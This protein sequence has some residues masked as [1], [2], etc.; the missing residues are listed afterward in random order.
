[1]VLFLT[2]LPFISQGAEKDHSDTGKRR[3]P[4]DYHE[5]AGD[6]QTGEGIQKYAED[7]QSGAQKNFGVQPVHD[8]EIFAVFRADRLEYQ[9]AEGNDKLLWDVQA[10]VGSD[11]NK[12][13][14]KSEGT[15]LTHP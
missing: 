11:Y 12:L 1:M 15:W 6:P 5:V 2:M 3:Y 13:W 9:T 14:F 7:A 10:W 4:A 8:N